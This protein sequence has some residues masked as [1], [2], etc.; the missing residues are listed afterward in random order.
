MAQSEHPD[1]LLFWK[2]RHAACFGKARPDKVT[3]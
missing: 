2:F 3:E 1:A